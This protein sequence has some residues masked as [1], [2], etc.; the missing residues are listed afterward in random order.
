MAQRSTQSNPHSAGEYRPDTCAYCQ[1][2]TWCEQRANGKPQC[3]A[4]KVERF[5]DLVLYPPLKLRL[6]KWQREDL[7]AVYGAV[8]PEDGVRRIR[9]VFESMAKKNGK[10]FIAGGLPIYHMICET[11]VQRQEA[12][13][14]AAAKD[15]AGIVFRA[16]AALVNAN[17]FLKDRLRIIDS[18]KRIVRRDGGGFYQVISADG[19]VQDGME[20]SLGI[21]DEIHRW[22]AEKAETLY[23][24]MTKGMASRE[25]ATAWEITTAGDPYKSQLWKDEYDYAKQ[26]LNGTLQSDRFHARIYEADQERL[27][28]DP[29]YWESREARVAANP[30]HEDLGGFLK[31][32]NIREDLEKAKRNSKARR[33]FYRLN[34]NVSPDM[35]AEG[36]IDP[37][38]WREF[39]GPIDLRD[40][41]AERLMLCGRRRFMDDRL[42]RGLVDVPSRGLSAVGN[43]VLLVAPERTAQ[44]ARTERQGSVSNVGR[45][46]LFRVDRRQCGR[47]RVYQG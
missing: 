38:T 19:D 28:K 11:H 17:S 8:R 39:A 2:E 27:K 32:E 40:W 46:G 10:S 34:L 4:C 21:L 47:L 31:D 16:A 29:K 45:P 5:F 6:L 43:V 36:A 7:R 42:N 3:R 14:A 33:D 25:E 23:T 44:E 37:V 24:V 1:A 30:S 22:T 20:P 13:G 41:S 26:I 18:T 12:Y 15:Q 9:R 35:L